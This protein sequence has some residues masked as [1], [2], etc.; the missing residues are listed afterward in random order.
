MIEVLGWVSTLLVLLGYVFN[1]RGNI[2][3]AMFIWITG[4]IGWIVYDFYIDN[5]SH[6]FLSLVI[7]SI[8]LY[9]IYRIKNQG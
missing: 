1:S 3:Y 4:D 7:I 6:L 8:N 2:R 9:G 5:I